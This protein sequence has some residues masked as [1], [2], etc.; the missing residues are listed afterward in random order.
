MK[1]EADF[2]TRALEL[3]SLFVWDYSWVMKVLE[4]MTKLDYNTLILHRN[5]IVECTEYPGGIFGYKN[6]NGDNSI[7]DVYS[8]CFSAIYKNTPT[9][10]SSVFNRRSY[11]KK[12]LVEAY[13]RKIAVYIENKELFFPDILTEFH[14]ELLHDGHVCP[15]DPYWK[16]Y[17][18]MKFQDFFRDYPEV[19]GVI[20]SVATSESRI[21]IKANRCHCDRCK[22]TKNEDWYKSILDT[23]YKVLTEFGKELIVRDFVFDS[24]SQKEIASVMEALPSDVIISLKNTP[25]DYYPTFPINPRIGKVGSHR[26]WIEFDTMGQYYGMG[27]SVADL[28]E[29]YR[30]RLEDAKDKGVCGTVFRT[31]W[32]SLDGNSSFLTPN[33]INVYSGAMLSKKITINPKTIY[34]KFVN[35]EGWAKGNP[36]PAAE[37]LQSILSK[38]WSVTS[39][40]V[41]VDGCVF[42]DSST[43][44][45]SMDHALW[46]AEDKNSL[47]DWD[48]SKK[49]SLLPLKKSL[50]HIL[51][52]KDE[53]K[54]EIDSIIQIIDKVPSCINEEK[55]KWLKEWMY[56]NKLYVEMFSHCAKL[57]FIARYILQTQETDSQFLLKKKKQFNRELK[58]LDGVESEL[59]KFWLKTDYFPNAIYTLLDPD[60]FDCFRRNIQRLYQWC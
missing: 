46:L 3:H 36:N 33:L 2:K 50:E 55:G 24:S 11:L 35:D 6:K 4:Y 57:I 59:Q 9:R 30:R 51:L 49:D 23:L 31:D 7:F 39:K 45:I 21:S 47:K 16:E 10:R 54:K 28:S 5:D 17:M 14:P 15:T 41:F 48:P 25:H 8:Q 43:L 1:R 40:T 52:E 22:Q 53:A 44:P 56:I 29:D 58:S 38:T 12:I 60:R 13:K 32:E 19:S 34:K 20:T 18:R 37:W 42:S 27:V 26:Q